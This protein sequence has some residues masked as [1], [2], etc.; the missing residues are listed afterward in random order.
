MIYNFAQTNTVSSKN[1]PEIFKIRGWDWVS[2]GKDN[3]YPQ[4]LLELYEKSSINRTCINSKSLGVFGEG[5]TISPEEASS[6]LNFINPDESW[7]DVYEKV[8]L[9]YEIFGG[10]ALQ[11]IWCVDGNNIAQIYHLPFAEVRSGDYKEDNKIHFYYYSSNWKNWRKHKPIPYP[12][13]DPSKSL[14][15]PTQIY[16]YQN[17]NPGSKY[18]PLPTYSGSL[19]D[20]ETDIA[21]STFHLNNLNNGLAPSLWVNFN[22]GVPD[23]TAQKAIY[24]NLTNEFSSP[25]NA[26]KFM[27]SFSNSKETAPDITPLKAENDDYYISLDKRIKESVLSGHHITSPSLLGLYQ[28]GTGFSSTADEIR[29]AFAHFKATVINPTTRALLKPLDMLLEKMYKPGLELNVAPLSILDS[30]KIQ[31]AVI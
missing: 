20:I 11:I 7:N 9:D 5:L 21:T 8:V 24:D 12:V 14:E 2:F 6:V 10:F 3:L 29:V 19:T 1:S 27:L 18:Y 25:T 28:T 23:P 31:E 30:E 15:E 13:Y 16:Y 26:G 22:D 4:Y 17:Y